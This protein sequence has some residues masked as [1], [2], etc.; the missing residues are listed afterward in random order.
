MLTVS[1][2]R[3]QMKS[4]FHNSLFWE[5]FLKHCRATSENIRRYSFKKFQ[6]CLRP[7][8]RNSFF[9]FSMIFR[10]FSAILQYTIDVRGPQ[11]KLVYSRFLFPEQIPVLQYL[12]QRPDFFSDFS[13]KSLGVLVPIKDFLGKKKNEIKI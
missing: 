5:C 7:G 3:P 13:K 4:D 10:K 11:K 6:I 9:K 8:L 1:S 2:R 12:K